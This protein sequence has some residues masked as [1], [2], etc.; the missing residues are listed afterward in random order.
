MPS[1]DLSDWLT[2]SEAARALGV[3]EHTLR[4]MTERGEGPERRDRPRP[5]RKPE[6]LYNPDDVDRLVAAKTPARVMATEALATTPDGQLTPGAQQLLAILERMAASLAQRPE[7]RALAAPEADRG[8][9]TTLKAASAQSGLSARLL[10]RLV[11]AGELPAIRDRAIKVRL[12]D[13]SNLSTALPAAKLDKS[14]GSR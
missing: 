11:A 7:P 8:P 1:A 4:R 10:R 9:W 6:P 13:V 5:G 3:N 2:R 14:K 12:G